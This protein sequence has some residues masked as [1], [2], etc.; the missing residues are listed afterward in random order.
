[1]RSGAVP[2]SNSHHDAFVHQGFNEWSEND[3]MAMIDFTEILPP[4][5]TQNEAKT[6]EPIVI[7]DDGISEILF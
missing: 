7:S 5:P 1:M 6:D 2:A 3:I 4:P